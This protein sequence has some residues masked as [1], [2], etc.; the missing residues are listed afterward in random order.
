MGSVNTG[1]ETQNPACVI[2]YNK[3]MGG[4][5]L[6]GQLLQMYPEGMEAYAQMVHEVIQK[7]SQC[8][9]AQCRQHHKANRWHSESTWFRP[10]SI[11]LTLMNAS[12]GSPGGRK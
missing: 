8:H 5:N 3:W 2:H 4:I 9:S 6:K 7:T 11:S 1:D 12:T 10:F